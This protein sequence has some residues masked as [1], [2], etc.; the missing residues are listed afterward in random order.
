[1]YIYCIPNTKI[2]KL[3]L[4]LLCGLVIFKWHGDSNKQDYVHCINVSKAGRYPVCVGL[5]GYTQPVHKY[6]CMRVV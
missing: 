5:C 6:T 3:Y 2:M 4:T 1:M